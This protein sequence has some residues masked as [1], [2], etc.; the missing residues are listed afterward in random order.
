[1]VQFRSVGCGPV[2]QLGARFHGMEEVKGSNPFRSTNFRSRRAAGF[3]HTRRRIQ[4]GATILLLAA[5]IVTIVFVT[6]EYRR[7]RDASRLLYT[8]AIRKN[9]IV[10]AARNSLSAL[11]DAEL[12]AQNYVLTGETVY[13]A[14][15]EEDIRNWE[16]EEATLELVARKDPANQ[17]VQDFA[18]AGKRTAGELG[19]VLSLYEKPGRDAALERIRS[20]SAIVYLDQAR[21]S[22]AKI[23]EVDGSADGSRKIIT[24][25]ETSLRRLAEAA[26]LLSCFTASTALLLILE[27]R[28]E[29]LR[30]QDARRVDLRENA[31]LH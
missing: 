5:A 9:D 2:A 11:T 19:A 24:R 6:R 29:R 13:S 28:R 12:R 17:Y 15:Y 22:V 30:G 25:A 7:D 16:D 23:L 14:A 3:S 20:S 1:M 4:I 26:V 21:G 8:G 10:D 27:I 31:A 18:K